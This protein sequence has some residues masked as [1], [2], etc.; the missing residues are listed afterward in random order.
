M[1]FYQVKLEDYIRDVPNFPKPGI[2]FKDITPLLGD[3]KAMELCVQRLSD[4]VS[5]QQIDKVIGIESR[6]FIFGS[7]LAQQLKAGFVPL[8]KPNKLPYKSLSESY[9]LEYGADTLE[10]H[11]DAIQKGERVLLH[12]DLLATGGTAKA[13][14]NLIERLGGVVV[15]CN[16]IIQLNTL[17]GVEKLHPY[18]VKSIISY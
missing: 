10:I 4:L 8:R 11:E 6:G 12:D 18:K 3:V 16:F 15:Q 7:L 1:Y 13:A 9:G 2:I 17:G 5:G 14:C